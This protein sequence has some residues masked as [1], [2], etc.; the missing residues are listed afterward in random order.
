MAPLCTKCTTHNK[1]ATYIN[2]DFLNSYV[3]HSHKTLHKLNTFEIQANKQVTIGFCLSCP[4]MDPLFGCSCLCHLKQLCARITK[5]TY[6][7]KDLCLVP[8]YILCIAV[9][10]EIASD[11]YFKPS[12]KQLYWLGCWFRYQKKKLI[13]FSLPL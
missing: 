9:I 10:I 6:V 4:C 8:L 1:K 12:S 7:G 13:F 2:V 5:H 11:R 3:T